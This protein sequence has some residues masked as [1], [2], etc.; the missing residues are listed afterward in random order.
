MQPQRTR[1]MH[2]EAQETGTTAAGNSTIGEPG[3]QPQTDRVVDTTT[4]DPTAPDVMGALYAG[5]RGKSK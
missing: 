5:S 2:V 4:S 1:H 3:G